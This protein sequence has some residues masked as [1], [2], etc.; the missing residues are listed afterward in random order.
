MEDEKKGQEVVQKK[1][2]GF[3]ELPLE[4][5][6]SVKEEDLKGRLVPS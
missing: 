6:R 2:R 1:K 4:Y 5:C 3:G